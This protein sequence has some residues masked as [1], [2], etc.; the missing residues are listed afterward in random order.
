SIRTPD[1]ARNTPRRPRERRCR[2]PDAPRPPPARAS[3]PRPERD[4]PPPPDPAAGKG[5]GSK[6]RCLSPRDAQQGCNRLYSNCSR[7]VYRDRTSQ[8]DCLVRRRDDLITS[9]GRTVKASDCDMGISAQ[10]SQ[11]VI[12]AASADAEIIC[13]AAG[14]QRYLSLFARP[15]YNSLVQNA[16]R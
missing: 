11:S 12:N 4:P 13:F 15:L 1:S 7:S 14:D 3:A 5:R 10:T 8:E 6:G 16:G 2:R 9:D